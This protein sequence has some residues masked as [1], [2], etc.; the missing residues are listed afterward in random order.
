MSVTKP[1]PSPPL[2]TTTKSGDRTV[3]VG[4]TMAISASIAYSVAH[5]GG[6]WRYLVRL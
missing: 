5:A 6:A 1:E 4:W 3:R 2:V